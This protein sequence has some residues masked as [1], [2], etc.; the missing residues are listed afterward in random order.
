MGRNLSPILQRELENLDKDANS[1]KSAMR[2]LKSY[3]RDLDSTAIPIFLAQVSE[4]KET[5]SVS[6]GYTISLYEVLARLHGVKIV[7]QIGIIMSTIIKTLASSADSFPLR[8]AC[9]KVFPAIARYGIGPTTP[10]DKRR[11]I[12]HSL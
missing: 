10:E 12:I 4:T 7:P 11:H 3:V 5:G 2:A 1:C 6:G 8:Q 9:S